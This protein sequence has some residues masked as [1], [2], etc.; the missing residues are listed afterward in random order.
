GEGA[1]V[2]AGHAL[3]A[4]YQQWQVAEMG[5]DAQHGQR[6]VEA[7]NQV[8]QL[9]RRQAFGEARRGGVVLVAAQG[10]GDL[11][12]Q[13]VRQL[14]PGVENAARIQMAGGLRDQFHGQHADQCL[15]ALG[16]GMRGQ[17]GE[18]AWAEALQQGAL[19]GQGSDALQAQ[20]QA[21]AVSGSFT[22]VHASSLAK[23]D[24][25]E[26]SSWLCGCTASLRWVRFRVRSSSP[27]R[28]AAKR[29]AQPRP[30]G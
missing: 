25:G 10:P 26:D 11:Q 16:L 17:Q 3:Q 19:Q 23:L 12:L 24:A 15:Q 18:S 4:L 20:Q 1:Q 2:A 21:Q 8:A 27:A 9:L 14:Q 6:V 28:A 30:A 22:R 29:I 7:E 5:A 13:V